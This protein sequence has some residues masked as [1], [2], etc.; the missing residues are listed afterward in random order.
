VKLR[1]TGTIRAT[2]RGDSV[3]IDGEVRHKVD[4][5]YDFND[6]TAVDRVVYGAVKYPAEFLGAKTF[7]IKGAKS[8]KMEGQITLKNG[9][10]GGS[11]FFISNE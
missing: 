8:Q 3:D 5:T 9:Q 7:R 1:S 2:R 10:I 11:N 4:N 6:D